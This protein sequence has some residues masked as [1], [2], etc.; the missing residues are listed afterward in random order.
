M[1]WGDTLLAEIVGVVGT[2]RLEG[3][4]GRTT[5]TT[6]YWDHRQVARFHK[7]AL[8]VQTDL[9]PERVVPAIRAAVHTVDPNLPLYNIRTLSAM[10][11]N[12]V[13]RSRFTTLALGTFAV[14]A[15]ILAAL[16]LYGVMA[17]T[18]QQRERE[19]G[20]RMA[21]GADRGSVLGMVLKQGTGVVLPALVTGAAGAGVLARFIQSLM[22]DVS[23]IDPV[24]FGGV[25][26]L[27]GSAAFLACWVPARRAA[28]VDPVAAIRAE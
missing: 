11:S 1:E 10:L 5:E 13:A 12:V 24:T 7:M 9:L 16:G 23:P 4:D 26:V 6:L 15:L 27:L 2:V 28:G 14:L 25:A 22:F 19:I 8:V 21:L 20:I 18:T 17:Y 3:P